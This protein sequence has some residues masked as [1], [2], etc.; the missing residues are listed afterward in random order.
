MFK[1][2]RP[3]ILPRGNMACM[4]ELH[5]N[6]TG[7]FKNGTNIINYYLLFLKF[8]TAYCLYRAQLMRL[9]RV[10]APPIKQSSSSKI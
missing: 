7:R 5:R 1:S 6:R 4:E 9:E 8:Y 3:I 2:S 10:L